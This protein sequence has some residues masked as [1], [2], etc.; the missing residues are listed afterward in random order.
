VNER[1][2]FG[3]NQAPRQA[4]PDTGVAENGVVHEVDDGFEYRPVGEY[5]RVTIT[6]TG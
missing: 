5:L 2:G 3:P 1:P 6:P 4:G